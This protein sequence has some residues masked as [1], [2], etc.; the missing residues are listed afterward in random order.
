[1]LLAISC[2][3]LA[4]G[5]WQLAKNQKQKAKSQKL[6]AKKNLIMNFTEQYIKR[7]NVFPKQLTSKPDEKLE[8]IVVIPCFNEPNLIQTLTSLQQNTGIKNPVE[9][10]VVVNSAENSSEQIKVSNLKTINE[11]TK[12]VKNNTN[13][14]IKF[15]LIHQPDLARKTAGVGLARKIGMDEALRRFGEINNPNGIIV[16]FDADSLCEQNYL[17]EISKHFATN[18]KTVA[19]SL[20]FEHPISGTEYSQNIYNA[21]ILYE[22]YLRYYNQALRFI[23][24]PFAFHTIGSAFAVKAQIYAK[25]G[26]MNTR[27]AGED[28]YFLQKIIPLGNFSEI[29]S[30]TVFPSPRISDRVPF[31]TG[32]SV[33][34]IVNSETEKYNTYNLK[35]F[36]LLK[37][38]FNNLDLLF[39][40]KNTLKIEL[41]EILISFLDKNNF[42]NALN[43]IN[44]NSS[45]LASFSK[46]FYSWFNA[47]RVLKFLNFAHEKHFKKVFIVDEA[48]KLLELLNYKNNTRTAKE[49]LIKYRKIN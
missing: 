40:E 24:F 41:S 27:K 11:T 2:W 14:K 3:L 13:K 44:K 30:T 19:C 29:N 25:Q 37:P 33:K 23:N 26:G 15:H 46:R 1:M 32:I 16:G 20:N 35:A 47:F 36:L 45:N 22:L 18:K 49:L 28:F 48:N 12:F 4:I 7:F 38:L 9:V 34:N 5:F 43:N 21:I 8:I 17:S 42:T 10:I 31:G 6:K 39:G